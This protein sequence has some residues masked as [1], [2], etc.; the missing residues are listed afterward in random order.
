[1]IMS[2]GP[3]PYCKKTCNREVT[4]NEILHDVD[5]GFCDLPYI[6]LGEAVQ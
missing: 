2:D 6:Y 4:V 3:I 5:C 1:M